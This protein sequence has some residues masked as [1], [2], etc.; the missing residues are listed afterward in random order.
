MRL[1]AAFNGLGLNAKSRYD[2]EGNP[3]EG[4]N[5]CLS[6]THYDKENVQDPDAE[7]PEMKPVTEQKYQ[8]GEKVYTVSSTPI[9]ALCSILY[10][11]RPSN[12][13]QTALTKTLR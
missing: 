9:D 2:D 8:V 1:A 13:F 5:Y 11:L 10:S 3:D 4:D 12:L 6:I 7:W